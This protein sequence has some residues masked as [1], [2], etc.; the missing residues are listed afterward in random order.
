MPMAGHFYMGLVLADGNYLMRVC[1]RCAVTFNHYHTTLNDFNVVPNTWAGAQLF[2]I[3]AL[4]IQVKTF[5][6]GDL[7][8]EMLW[9][10]YVRYAM[11]A[12]MNTLIERRRNP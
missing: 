11:C 9:C 12:H 6:L 10:R 2:P 8:I 4:I 5:D 3:F 7:L 1:D